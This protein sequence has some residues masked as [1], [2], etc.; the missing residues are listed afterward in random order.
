M[1]RKRSKTM[2]K[3]VAKALNILE[4]LAEEPA[5]PKTLKE[6]SS[7]FG[8]HPATCANIIKTMLVRRFIEQQAPR[9]GYTLGP[10]AFFLSG[11]AGAYRS[12]LVDAAR[13]E[14]LKLAE[15]ANESVLLITLRNGRRTVLCLVEGSRAVQVKPLSMDSGQIYETATGRLLMAFLPQEAARVIKE[16][17]MP[18]PAW[19]E[20]S[21][22]ERMEA[23]LAA[24][25]KKSWAQLRRND[26]VALAF[27]I[28]GPD[29]QVEAALGLFLPEYR[30]KGKHRSLVL[31]G[32]R[33][34]AE[35]I[36]K[37]RGK[38]K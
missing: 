12:G 18:G 3:A 2:I 25:R 13:P 8:M 33:S 11:N 10:A 14:M 35:T 29:R 37:R 1:A 23:E 36:G 24:I 17:G 5:Q 6:I 9:R 28:F 38:E 27:P 4:A 32:L 34:A 16:F 22:H 21:S 15:S 20:A 31:R 19:P 7:R 26:L 30:F